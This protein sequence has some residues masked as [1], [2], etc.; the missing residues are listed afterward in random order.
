MAK[1]Q[2]KSILRKKFAMKNMNKDKIEALE[3]VLQIINNR[4]VVKRTPDYL[5][6][7]DDI[8]LFVEAAIERLKNGEEMYLTAECQ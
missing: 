2:P 5:A 1:C 3:Y 7:G 4:R 6:C 8:K